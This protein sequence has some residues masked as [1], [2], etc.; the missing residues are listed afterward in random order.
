MSG[1]NLYTGTLDLL[2]LRALRSGPDHGYG[3]G[4]WI[5]ETSGD[6][7]TVEEGVLYPALHRLEAKG[8]LASR[9]GKSESNRR[10]KFYALT[11]AGRRSLTAETSRWETH[12]AAVA[13]LLGTENR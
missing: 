6:V 9:W 10:A 13:A 11:P 3:I 7:L 12:A 1:S 5:R 2:I 4:A 8:W